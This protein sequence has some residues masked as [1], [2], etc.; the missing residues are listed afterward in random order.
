MKRINCRQLVMTL[1]N[2]E[3][4]EPTK[5]GLLCVYD[6]LDSYLCIAVFTK[7]KTCAD[8][9]GTS[10]KTINWMV[11]T[12]TVFKGRFRIERVKI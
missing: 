9:F 4:G 10:V 1:S 6:V 2:I 3:E 11:T 12:G 8:F 5:W 7:S